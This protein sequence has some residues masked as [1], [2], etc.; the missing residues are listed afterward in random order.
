MADSA[1]L[2]P[3]LSADD[4]RAAE[5]VCSKE[6]SRNGSCPAS[7]R[8]CPQLV[9]RRENEPWLSRGSSDGEG[10]PEVTIP[11]GEPVKLIAEVVDDFGVVGRWRYASCSIQ[12]QYYTRR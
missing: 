12:E 10:G 3:E 8:R 5:W 1:G 7:K 11:A 4:D 6:S 9:R 2:L